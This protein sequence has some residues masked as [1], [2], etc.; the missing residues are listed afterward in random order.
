MNNVRR[1]LHLAT[2]A[3]PPIRKNHPL[4]AFSYSDIRSMNMIRPPRGLVLVALWAVVLGAGFNSLVAQQ[5]GHLRRKCFLGMVPGA[6]P[7]SLARVSGHAEGVLATQVVPGGTLEAIGGQVN[8]VLLQVNGQAVRN[9]DGLRP[10]LMGMFE[11]DAVTLHV[12]R[13]GKKPRELDLKGTIRGAAREQG[14]AKYD[15]L[16][17]E[18]AFDG[19]YLRTI[20]MLPKTPGPHPVIYF[21]PGYN[22][23]SIDNMNVNSPYRKLFDSLAT[24]GNIIYRVEKPGMGDG[25][26][27][28]HCEQT[29][30]EKELSAFE[31]GYRNLLAQPW[32]AEDRVFMVGHSMGGVQ[33]PLLTAKGAHPRGIAVYGTVYET[34][35]EYIIKMLRF[36]ETRTGEDYLAFEK[37]MGEY[38][39]LFYAHYVEFKPLSEIVKNPAWKALLE[40]DFLLDDQGN[41]LF[42]RWDYW[43]EIARHTLADVWAK[44]DAHVLSMYGEA[45]FEVFDEGSMSEI[46]R[47]VN[48][49]HPGHG[50][51]VM[52]PRTDHGMIEVGTMEEAL[53]IRDTPAYRDYYLNHFNWRIVTEL[54]GWIRGVMRAG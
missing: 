9:W 48:A 4:P 46:A 50:K 35:Y 32:A 12:W 45:D 18:A 33:A 23:F 44:T 28:C 30:F 16:Y 13:G 42:R 25:P 37:D 21:I 54:D 15:V 6:V 51:Y 17:G 3:S 34:W 26:S 10:I 2:L 11:G 53:K 14:N 20:T 41:L 19:G 7:D 31:A 52:I 27:P 8:D 47:I 24:L 29:G 1:Y 43:Q 38:V 22:C 36:Q 39:K 40:R 5:P 49:Y